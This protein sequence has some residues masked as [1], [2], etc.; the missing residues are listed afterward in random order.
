M[1]GT[2]YPREESPKEI[3]SKLKD[4]QALIYVTL[5]GCQLIISEII[6]R[7]DNSELNYYIKQVYEMLEGFY[8]GMLKQD[9]I[10]EELRGK[11]GLHL[12]RNGCSQLV[13]YII[14]LIR[15]F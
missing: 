14:N 5:P 12:N 3:I 1:I 15:S 9:I 2:N 7:K 4:L 13:Y 6:T 10:K 8:M 11:N